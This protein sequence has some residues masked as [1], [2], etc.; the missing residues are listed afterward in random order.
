MID[1]ITHP[2]KFFKN[3]I[4]KD[5][6]FKVPFLLVLAL[7]LIYSSVKIPLYYGVSGN[8]GLHLYWRFLSRGIFKDRIGKSIALFLLQYLY[9]GK[10]S[11]KRR[12]N[13]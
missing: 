10:G 4:E 2:D 1:F 9:H 11:F 6:D 8:A 3:K 13:E 7:T 12:Q 5:I